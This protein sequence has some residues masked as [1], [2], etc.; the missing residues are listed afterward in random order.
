MVRAVGWPPPSDTPVVAERDM[1]EHELQS[2]LAS[3]GLGLGA[4]G[5]TVDEVERRLASIARA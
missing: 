5:E 1:S 3:L 4:I 2:F